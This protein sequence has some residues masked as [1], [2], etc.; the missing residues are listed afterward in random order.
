MN[1]L[2]R[3]NVILKD[4]G[5]TLSADT[6][7]KSAMDSLDRVEFV[8]RLEQDFNILITDSQMYEIK[9]LQDVIGLIEKKW[10]RLISWYA[11]LPLAFF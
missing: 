9:T 8:M 11:R 6:E 10:K 7:I 2:E 1:T 4:M 3:I 5:I